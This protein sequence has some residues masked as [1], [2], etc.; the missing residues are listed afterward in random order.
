MTYIAGAASLTLSEISADK[1][2][3]T[4]NGTDQATITVVVRDAYG[5]TVPGRAVVLE[6]SGSGNSLT[7]PVGVT[8]ANGSG[9]R[10]RSGR[11]LQR[12]RR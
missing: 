12:Q 2:T 8:G 9:D 11:R 10:V 4:A 7:Q 1:A 6:M 3:V 5:N